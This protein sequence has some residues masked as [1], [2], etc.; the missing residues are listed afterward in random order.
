MNSLSPPSSTFVLTQ[1]MHHCASEQ[2]AN[3]QSSFFS[4]E[5]ET[6][7]GEGEGGRE[8]NPNLCSFRLDMP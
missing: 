2:L 3:I 8:T 4:W 7:V 5:A 6:G 1:S